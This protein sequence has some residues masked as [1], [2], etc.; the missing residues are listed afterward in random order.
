MKLTKAQVKD[1]ALKVLEVVIVTGIPAFIG[2]FAVC[3][4]TNIDD[5]KVMLAHASVVAGS[6]IVDVLWNIG[7]RLARNFFNDGKLTKEEIE[8]A[9]DVDIEGGADNE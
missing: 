6:A 7:K 1:I 5:F 4:F 3:K 2:A 9:F 8:S